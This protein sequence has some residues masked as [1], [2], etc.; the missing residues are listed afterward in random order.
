MNLKPAFRLLIFP[1]FLLVSCDDYKMPENKALEKKLI[2]EWNS[3]SLKI[4]MN[5]FSNRD[6]TRVFEVDESNWEK[7]MNIRPVKTVYFG[8]GTFMAEHRNLNDSI[9]F[10]PFGTWTILGDTIVLRDT[11]PQPG[12]VYKY[13]IVIK[14]N[15]TEFFGV[16]DCDNDGTADDNYYGVQRKIIRKK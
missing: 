8:D 6:S 3:T 1:L 9:I 12:P 14:D 5:T 13:K 7:E 4:T 11:F 2:G 15:I 10:N 16:E